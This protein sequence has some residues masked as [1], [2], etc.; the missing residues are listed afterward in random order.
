[1]YVEFRK[2]FCIL[3]S[4]SVVLGENKDEGSLKVSFWELA[5]VD[6]GPSVPRTVLGCCQKGRAKEEKQLYQLFQLSAGVPQ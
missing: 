4:P 6:S 5:E 2:P 1:M 3:L